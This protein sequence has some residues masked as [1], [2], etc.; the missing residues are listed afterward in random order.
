MEW[1]KWV[2]AI[3]TGLGV[4]IPLVIKLM[5]AAQQAVKERNWQ[6]VVTFVLERMKEA[7]GKFSTGEERKEWVL[8]CVKAAADSLNYDIDLDAIGNM[9]DAF[10]EMA[11]TVNAGELPDAEAVDV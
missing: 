7:E 9:I 11:Q 3:L 10:A 6:K 1:L 5:E 4:C 8:T 2:A